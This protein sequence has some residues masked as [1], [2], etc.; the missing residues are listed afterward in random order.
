MVTLK[1]LEGQFEVSVD[2]GEPWTPA[3]WKTWAL[4]LGAQDWN[5]DILHSG[6]E[7]TLALLLIT[8]KR[9]QNTQRANGKH[10][11]TPLK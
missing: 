11:L 5:R 9:Y 7:I 4:V 6:S 10:T 2:G 8:F 3:V 1:W